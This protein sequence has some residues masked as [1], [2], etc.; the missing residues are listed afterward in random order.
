MLEHVRA[1]SS[2]Q[3]PSYVIRAQLLAQQHFGIRWLDNA[4]SAVQGASRGVSLRLQEVAHDADVVLIC[5]SAEWAQT[6]VRQFRNA[7]NPTPI[8]VLNASAETGSNARILD[9][10]ADDCLT[11]PF[12][13]RELRARVHAVLRRLSPAL[14]RT[15]LIAMDRGTLRIRVRA[16]QAHVSPRQL[17]IFTCLAERRER[18]VHSEEIIAVVS[19]THHDPGSSL[20]RVQIHALRKALGAERNC[21]RCDGRKSYMLTLAK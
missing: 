8:V 13:A 5:G 10:G 12:E 20:V 17:E 9:E 21:I 11:C 3:L 1:D 7:G 18:W 6:F 2:W 14:L 19:G 4:R 16:V 15:P